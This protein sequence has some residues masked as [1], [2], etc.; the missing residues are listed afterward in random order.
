MGRLSEPFQR[1]SV[2]LVTGAENAPIWDDG[3][4]EQAMRL[5]RAKLTLRSM[6][7][8]MAMLAVVFWVAERRLRFQRLAEY[9]FLRSSADIVCCVVL[10]TDDG[11]ETN[12]VEGG[13]GRPT[14]SDRADWHKR[15]HEKYEKAARSPWLAVASDPPRPE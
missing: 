3:R 4:R 8:V 10:L 6:M 1:D 14:T 9:H 5:P 13:T 7:V 15:L 2:I 11:K 12:L